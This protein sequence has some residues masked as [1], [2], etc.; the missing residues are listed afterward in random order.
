M[1]LCIYVLHIYYRYIVMYICYITH[2]PFYVSH[3]SSIIYYIYSNITSI[4]H[5]S[6]ITYYITYMY[7]CNI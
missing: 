4:L 1:Y 2:K 7:I 3:V 6:N 5:I